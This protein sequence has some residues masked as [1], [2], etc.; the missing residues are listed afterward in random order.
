MERDIIQELSKA[1]KARGIKVPAL[2][3]KLDIPKDRI[4]KWFQQGT[5]PKEEDSV[6][7]WKWINGGN[8]PRGTSFSYGLTDMREWQAAV[9]AALG[10][11]MAEIVP[12][13]AKDGGK[14]N[15][16]VFSQL[17]KDISDETQRLLD[18]LKK[19]Q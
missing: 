10:V 14:S 7:L 9:D 8:D 1:M 2:S 18:E 19:G 4:Y 12:I 17:K 5:K 3:E 11:I 6:K 13:L 16:S 15:A